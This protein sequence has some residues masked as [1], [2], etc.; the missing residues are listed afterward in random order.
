[1]G[2]S[3]KAQGY[4]AGLWPYTGVVGVKAPVFSM[5][6]LTGVDNYLGPEMK[7]TGEVMG[8][9]D[10]FRPA[11]AKALMASNLSLPPQG[12]VLVSIADKDKPESVPLIR[13]FAEAGYRLYATEGTAAMV[14]ALGYDVTMTTKRLGEGSP[15]MLDVI[16]D[17][18]VDAVVNTVNEVASTLRDGFE[19]RRAAV[20]HRIPCFTSL[21][22]ARA[23]IES[24]LHDDAGYRILSSNDYF[25]V[26]PTD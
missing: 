2:H 8:V 25:K 10:A 3:L 26:R 7:S 6:K 5:S 24:L 4:E 18:T 14:R 12:A 1:M 21:D 17:G 9:D 13:A 22:T 11:V 23:A 20:E 19:I 15:D 16:N